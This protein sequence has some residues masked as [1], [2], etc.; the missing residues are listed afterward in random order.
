MSGDRR[1]PDNWVRNH[2][3]PSSKVEDVGLEG[4]CL[5]FEAEGQG[6]GGAGF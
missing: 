6:V 3:E 2:P 4:S 5:A 1:G